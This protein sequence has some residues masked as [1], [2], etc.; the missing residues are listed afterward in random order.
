MNR[1]NVTYII[2]KRLYDTFVKYE[3]ITAL[4]VAALIVCFITPERPVKPIKIIGN[5]VIRG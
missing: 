1:M 3:K 2:G 5:I 4:W